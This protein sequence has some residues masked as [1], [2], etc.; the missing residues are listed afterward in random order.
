MVEELWVVVLAAGQGKRMHSSLPK[1]LHKMCGRPMLEYVLKSAGELTKNI[2]IVV[3]HGKGLVKEAAG[4]GFT[5][6]WQKEQRGTGH[7]VMQAF[8]VLPEK[9]TLLVLCGDVPLITAS[10]LKALLAL[11]KGSPAVVATAILKEP[12]GYGRIVRGENG[13]V[14]RIVEE[15]EAGTQEKQITEINTGTYCFDISLLKKYLPLVGSDN[16]QN[17]YYLTDVL[18]HLNQTGSF[19]KACRLEDPRLGLGINNRVELSE[20]AALMQKRICRRLQLKGVTIED[21]HLVQIDD[22]TEVGAG[23][24]IRPFSLLEKGTVVGRRCT[25]GP[26]AHLIAALVEDGAAVEH[27]LVKNNTIARGAYKAH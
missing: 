17:E 22:D 12:T 11:K 18:P 21:P 6:V 8:A 10:H 23:T 15:K 13:R 26:F 9:G 4:E 16:A 1:V 20:A 27:C 7:A 14:L 2:C 3:G 25:I 19:V 24:L 5:Y